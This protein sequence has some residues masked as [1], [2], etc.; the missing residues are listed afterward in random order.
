MVASI[1]AM[2]LR[3]SIGDVLNRI[4][5]RGE[6]VV[7]ERKGEPVAAI[8]GVADLRRLETLEAEREMEFTAMAKELLAQDTGIRCL[9]ASCSTSTPR[10]TASRWTYPTMYSLDLLAPGAQ[11]TGRHPT[12]SGEGLPP[13]ALKIFALGQNPRPQ[14]V[15]NIG[16]DYRVDS[17]EYRI[18]YAIDDA[19]R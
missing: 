16:A 5:Y 12:L 17:G 6:R 9:T 13:T 14:D 2:Q 18:Y 15:Q 4:Q 19:H 7:V 1:S 11:G 10:C 8:I 3:A